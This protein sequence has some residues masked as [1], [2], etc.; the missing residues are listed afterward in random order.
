VA[1]RHRLKYLWLNLAHKRQAEEDLAREIDSYRELLEEENLRAGDPPDEARRNALLELGGAAQIQEEVRDARTGAGLDALGAE[2]RQSLRGLRRNPSL[3]LLGILMLG[4]GIGAGTVVFSIFHAALVEAMPFHDPA[5]LVELWETRRDAGFD[6][7]SFTEANFW[8]LRSQTRAFEEV[9]TYHYD[10]SNLTGAGQPEKVSSSLVSTNFFRTLGVAPVLGRDFVSDDDRPG[11]ANRPIVLGYRYWQRRFGGDRAVLGRTLR[12]DD[13]AC[14]V[15]GVLPPGE[16]W[17]N[18][19]IYV[20]FGHRPNADRGS[21]EFAVVGRMAPGVSA[22]AAR[23]D[24]ARVAALL[25]QAYPKEDKSIGFHFEPASTWIASASTRR[26]LVVLLSAVG[27]LMLIA[28]IN[29]ANLLLARGTA[30]RREIAVRVAL[31]AGR[32]RLIRFVMME[33]LL[34]SLCG[35]GL[36]L[37]LAYGSLRTIRSLEFLG[38]PRLEHA[39]LNP[40]VLGFAAL[41]ALATGI[42][43]GLLPA[44]RAPVTAISPVLR[45]SDRQAAG[46]GQGRLRS[47]LVASEV[48]LSFLLLVGA[49]LLIRSF[50]QLLTVNRGFQTENRLMF[51]VNLPGPYFEKGMSKYFV[52]RL[53]ERLQSSPQVIAVGA[54]NQRPVEGGDPGMGIDAPTERRA[55]PWAGWRVV[56]PGYFQAVGLALI[57]GRLFDENDKP[58]WPEPGQ[59]KP[60]R[61]V[62]ISQRLATLIFPNLDP[63]GRHVLL[64]KS[65]SGG[66]AEVIGVVADSR[67]RGLAAGPALTVYLPYGRNAVPSE[68]VVHTRGNPMALARTVRSMVSEIDPQLPVSDVR[69]FEEVV[70]RSVAPQRFDAILL[71]IFSGLALLLAMTGIYGVLSYSMG[72]RT[73]EIG[74]RVALGANR[75]SILWMAVTQGMR[76]ALAG[77]AAG[78]I[79]AWWLSRYFQTL[80]FEV[81]P[82]DGVTYAVVAVLLLATALAACAVPGRRAM[83]IDPAVALRTE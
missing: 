55:P 32:A 60:V 15:V 64:W 25:E 61:R 40:W 75:A 27:F 9:A 58:V 1:L 74:L 12:L 49:G 33:A 57:R 71:G 8:D 23:A 36:G 78:A 50:G 62:I 45:D 37:A 43:S 54:V 35:A 13:R 19:Q 76:P 28:C 11:V 26:A 38:I 51:T 79:G 10:E 5:R 7:A 66:D 21:F 68:F 63:V 52:D 73:A 31:G 44:L 22:G 81:K 70:N 39:G 77:A 3:A 20:P 29:L 67:E 24:L 65:Q 72:R 59:P 17:I 56:S 34:L 80:L 83:R 4:L 47:A 18:D 53:S 69:T 82:V 42:L 2:L 6:H 14:V 41:I 16:P 48:A 46:R 30:R